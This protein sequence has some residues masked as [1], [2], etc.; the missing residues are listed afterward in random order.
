M[1]TRLALAATTVALASTV[2]AQPPTV[3]ST[4]DQQQSVAVTVYTAGRGMVTDRRTLDLPAGQVAVEFRDVAQSI[5]P[6]TVGITA[7]GVNVLE[8]NYEYDLLSPK[9]LLAKYVGR[10][11]EMELEEPGATPG[12]TTVRRVPATLLSVNDGTVWRMDDRI[13][14]NPPYHRLLFPKVPETLRERPTLVWLLSS[15]RAG[16]R[17]LT[18]TYLTGG[19][20]WHADYVLTLGRDGARGHMEGW[21]TVDNQSGTGFTNARLRLIAGEVHTAQPERSKGPMY[22]TMEAGATQA[23]E[24]TFG[25][26]HLYTITRPVTLKQNQIK[27][28]SLLSAADVGVGREYRVDLSGYSVTSRMGGEPQRPPVAVRL[29]LRNDAANNLGVPL[30]KGVIRVYREHADGSAQFVGEDRI[31]HT[32]KDE[33]VALD[34]GTAFDLVAEASQTDFTKLGERASESSFKVVLRNHKAEAVTVGVVTQ[35]PGDWNVTAHSHPVTKL[36]ASH[37]RFDVPVAADGE[38]TLTWTVRTRW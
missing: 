17:Q 6:E 18:A 1:I 31:G 11:I 5:M 23:Q 34:L 29:S 20:S 3:V 30:P 16:Q 4:A 26:Y 7:D 38:V 36:D 22:R 32:P 21:I 15:E 35:M 33:T 10:E 28:V 27:Q 24:E 12:S 19:M 14:L 13:V 8:Q 9:T 37:A 25:E 2:A